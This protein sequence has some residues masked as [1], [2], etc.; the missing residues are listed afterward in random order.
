M[1]LRILSGSN[2]TR[3][4]VYLMAVSRK[5]HRPVLQTGHCNTC[6]KYFFTAFG[7]SQGGLVTSRL[8]MTAFK[9]FWNTDVAFPFDAMKKT[10]ASF[11][12]GGSLCAS[13]CVCLAQQLISLE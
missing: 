5:G 12:C 13:Q 11:E 1:Y 7:P 2:W 10:I 8:N 6:V 4:R 3:T 9:F